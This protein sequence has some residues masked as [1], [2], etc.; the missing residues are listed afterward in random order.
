MKEEGIKTNRQTKKRGANLNIHTEKIWHIQ[1]AKSISTD[2]K[3]D[4]QTEKRFTNRQL[5][6]WKNRK[7]T[8]TPT[9][10]RFTNKQ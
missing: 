2:K 3:T 7:K 4:T 6:E 5:L 8:D 9:K 1:S 10:K